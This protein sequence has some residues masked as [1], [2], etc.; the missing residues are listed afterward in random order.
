MKEELRPGGGGG[1]GRGDEEEE[2]G[3]TRIE[4]KEGGEGERDREF[5]TK[6]NTQEV[7]RHKSL[8]LCHSDGFDNRICCHW[9][10]SGDIQVTDI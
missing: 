3:E 10:Y 7:M 1:G 6:A 4:W 5:K 9:R 2:E 8:S